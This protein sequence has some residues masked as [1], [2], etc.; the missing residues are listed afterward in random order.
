[1]VDENETKDAPA[2][3]EDEAEDEAHDEHEG[4]P[5]KPDEIDPELI[6]LAIRRGTVGP[7]L[8]LSIIVFCV[9]IMI[10]LVADYSFSRHS[11]TPKKIAHVDDIVASGKVGPEEFVALW[12][13]PDQ[14]FVAHLSGTGAR[15]GHRLAPVLGSGSKLWLLT[16]ATPWAEKPVYNEI[17]A[18]RLRRLD[19]LPFA[20]RLRSYVRKQPAAPRFVTDKAVEASLSDG[21]DSVA[22]PFGDE[23]AVSPDTPVTI[24][25]TVLD[26]ARIEAFRTSLPDEKTA[27][28]ALVEA[29]VLTDADEP[30]AT[31]KEMFVYEVAAPEGLAAVRARLIAAKQFGARAEPVLR[32]HETTWANLHGNTDGLTIAGTG[33]MPWSHVS[34]IA[35]IVPRTIP[36]NALV[37]LTNERP[38]AYWYILPLY[39][40]L[41]VFVLL[42]LWALIQYFRRD[43]GSKTPSP[44]ESPS[45]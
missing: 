20:G 21:R 44:A 23:I 30:I 34:S 40:V 8:S 35:L 22:T 14:S 13:V 32:S 43:F 31:S 29:G 27:R 15:Y 26:R 6:S 24:S 3:A 11:D 33:T 16:E 25:E 12:A 28:T 9:Y 18:G 42:F 45:S 1:M 36:S 41:G 5:R 10:R 7:L 38:G 19:D 17:Q 2:E 39:V 37:L 4:R